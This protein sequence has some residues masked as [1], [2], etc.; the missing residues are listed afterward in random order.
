MNDV[1]LPTRKGVEV[2]LRCVTIPEPELATILQK[3][4]LEPPKR[5]QNNPNL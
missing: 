4:K 5:L 1:V 2:R 3:L